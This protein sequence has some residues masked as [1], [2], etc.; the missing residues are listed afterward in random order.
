MRVSNLSVDS[1][2]NKINIPYSEIG[3]HAIEA[4]NA[5]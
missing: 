1:K 4:K 5:R 2:K 3:D